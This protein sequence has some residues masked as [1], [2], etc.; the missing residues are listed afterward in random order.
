MSSIIIWRRTA[1]SGPVATTCVLLWLLTQATYAP[2]N[3]TAL[4]NVTVLQ[5]LPQNEAMTIEAGDV[6]SHELEMAPGD[7][8][9]LRVDQQGIDLRLRLLSPEGAEI[10]AVDRP[11]GLHG[12]EEILEIVQQRGVYRLE[13]IAATSGPKEGR[14]TFRVVEHR[15]ALPEDEEK[16]IADHAV[17]EA[18]ALMATPRVQDAID[19]LLP[20]LDTWRKWAQADRQ[21][22]VGLLLCIAF[23]S[24]GQEDLALAYGEQAV[25]LAEAGGDHQTAGTTLLHL[26]TIRQRLNQARLAA[27][28]F[29]AALAHFQRPEW[30][31]QEIQ[32]WI[33]LGG[34]QQRLG[35]LRSALLSFEAAV[36]LFEKWPISEAEEADA[37][38]GYGTLLIAL[39]R[40]SEAQDQLRKAEALYRRVAD[41]PQL[42]LVVNRL[43]HVAYRLGERERAKD[44]LVE[45]K[46]LF[47]RSGDSSRVM[48]KELALAHLFLAR[49]ELDAMSLE[50]AQRA[51]Q[52]ALDLARRGKE[53]K[54]EAMALVDLGRI[55]RHRKE[56][57]AGLQRT[58]EAWEI[59]RQL[60]E[61]A[62][63]ALAG[64]RSAE[65]LYDLGRSEE[66]WHLIEPALDS[67]ESQR[68]AS[69]RSDVRIDVFAFRQDFFEIAIDVLMA[70]HEVEPSA[71]YQLKALEVHE[72]RRARS[73]LDSLAPATE[74]LA[75]DDPLVVRERSLEGELRYLTSGL[76]GKVSEKRVSELLAGLQQVRGDLRRR[77][78]E[79]TPRAALSTL[80]V[81]RIMSA[82]ADDDSMIL[83]YS[84]GDR[85]S[86]LWSI[87]EGR[88]A[89]YRLPE[90][91][92]IESQAALFAE[93]AAQIGERSLSTTRRAGQALS[94]LLLAPVAG[95]LDDRRLVIVANGNLQHIPFAALPM[96]STAQKSDYLIQHHEVVVLPSL[97]SLVLLRQQESQRPIS[98][99]GIIA[100]GNPVFSIDDPRVD[101]AVDGPRGTAAPD[102]GTALDDALISQQRSVDFLAERLELDVQRPLPGSNVEVQAIRTLAEAQGI[103]MVPFVDFDARREALMQNDLTGYRVLHIATHAFQD[104]GFPELSALIL[105][106]VDRRGRPQNG[107]VRAFEISRLQLSLELVVL[108]A[109][110]T[111]R[112]KTQRGEG[113]MG[114][115]RA[116][117]HA[118]VS[119]LVSSLWKVDDLSTARLMKT[120]YEGFLERGL[121][122]SAAL[123]QAQIELLG[124]ARTAAP[125][126]WAGFVFQGEWRSPPKAPRDRFNRPPN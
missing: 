93:H 92:I 122:A 82:L 42:A 106:M 67:A 76:A 95:Q 8:L 52:L 19:L 43:A 47:S 1:P 104:S 60:E 103:E 100:F 11:N 29:M 45:A 94:E 15:A 28:H 57:T 78:Q 24:A 49:I 61:P 119:Q 112:G 120:F 48:A 3:P 38:L 62:S 98:S 39:Q 27:S 102:S 16:V 14:L 110:E 2:A 5:T 83:V 114:L 44:L 69:D 35:D 55:L 7:F 90:R 101:G 121:P 56:P 75:E 97:S 125:Y 96:P 111:G 124:N 81:P 26:G 108:S 18:L 77:Q 34:A 68:V 70:Q 73:L 22:E 79:D 63:Q 126:H 13:V 84:L 51:A 53:R 32:A 116:F 21:A 88:V 118:G 105:S 6:R 117:L 71:G 113:V 66:A 9:H 115:S 31:R 72:R 99:G 10:Y 20:A 74:P 123:R 107:F 41:L 25:A 65:A 12:P 89:A 50:A 91:A 33:R 86:Y 30:K 58:Q 37:H 87:V 54:L 64:I 109:C 40:P 4:E 17:Y 46:R 59:F 23:H 36:S 85:N 80:E